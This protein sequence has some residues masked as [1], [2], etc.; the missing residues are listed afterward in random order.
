MLTHAPAVPDQPLVVV[1]VWRTY[2][3]G[4][5]VYLACVIPATGKVRVTTPVVRSDSAE[6]ALVT[7]S[8]RV[9]QCVGAMTEDC[10]AFRYALWVNGLVA[11]IGA[12]K[13]QPDKVQ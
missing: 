9:Y 1:E 3:I 12:F 4:D 8:G 2:V 5:E 10:I 13:G 7:T 6:K 11:D